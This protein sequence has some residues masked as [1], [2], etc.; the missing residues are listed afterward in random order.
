LGGFAAQQLQ[1]ITKVRLMSGGLMAFGR[2]AV[3]T[4]EFDLLFST[5]HQYVYGLAQ[6]LLGN[7]QDAEDVTQEVFLRLYKYFSRF[8]P[9]RATMRTWLA[10]LTVNA[11]RSHRKRNFLRRLMSRSPHQEDGET[12]NVTDPSTW[13]VPEARVLRDELRQAVRSVLDG[14]KWEHKAVLVLHYYM[15]MPCPEI[16]RV[17]ECPEGTVYSRLHHARRLVQRKLEKGMLGPDGDREAR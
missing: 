8:D 12:D 13:S 10:H 7:P 9:Q 14:L 3:G 11:C 4:E 16:A 5:H 1:K 6:G 2:E 15:D 17:M